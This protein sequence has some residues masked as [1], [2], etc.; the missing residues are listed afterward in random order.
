MVPKACEARPW[1]RHGTRQDPK[2][3]ITRDGYHVILLDAPPNL[4]PWY[5]LFDFFVL[6]IDVF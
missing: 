6:S 1:P 2:K 4:S 5:G 3:I